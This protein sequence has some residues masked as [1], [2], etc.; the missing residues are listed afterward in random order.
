MTNS[1]GA[2]LAQPDVSSR[3]A[4]WGKVLG[5]FGLLVAIVV[6]TGAMNPRFFG[7]ENLENVLQRTAL[8]GRPK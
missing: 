1:S 8:F 6:T 7:A 4:G 3:L 2:N 5:I